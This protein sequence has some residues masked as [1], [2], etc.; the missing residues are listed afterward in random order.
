MFGIFRFRR[1]SFPVFLRLIWICNLLEILVL[2]IDFFVVIV[3]VLVCLNDTGADSCLVIIVEITVGVLTSVSASWL[4]DNL[5]SIGNVILIS[6]GGFDLNRVGSFLASVLLSDPWVLIWHVHRDGLIHDM[7][8]NQTNLG[9]LVRHSL[10]PVLFTALCN[11]LNVLLMWIHHLLDRILPVDLHCA[12]DSPTTV[13][14]LH[15]G[16]N[17]MRA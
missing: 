3:I 1:L 11:R 5:L 15:F 4:P 10:M 17:D 16:R 9:I 12:S 6:W 13:L 8:G 2:T 7:W 14:F